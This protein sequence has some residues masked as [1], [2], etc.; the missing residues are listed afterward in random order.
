MRDMNKT[1]AQLVGEL[2]EMRQRVAVLEASDAEDE[3]DGATPTESEEKLRIVF[4]SIADGVVVIDLNGKIVEVNESTLRMKGYSDKSEVIGRDGLGFISEKDR[5]KA[6]ELMP[7]VIEKGHSDP[8]EYSLLTKSGDEVEV[9]ANCRVLHDKEG[10]PVGLVCVE[11]DISQRKQLEREKEESKE[12]L[13]P[14]S[15]LRET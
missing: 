12:K 13:S 9:E 6:L 10:I 2:E 14:W 4:D 3:R 5:K 1:K 15:T 8:R 7:D 11:R